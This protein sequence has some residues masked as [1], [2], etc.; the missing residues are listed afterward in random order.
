MNIKPP[1]KRNNSCT[2]ISAA[3][4]ARACNVLCFKYHTSAPSASKTNVT[5]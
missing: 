4:D 2:S 3:P 5:T 1:E